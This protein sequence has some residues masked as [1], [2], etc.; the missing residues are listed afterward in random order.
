ML[1]LGLTGLY[2][3]EC[4]SVNEVE[5]RLSELMQSDA[6]A[7]IVDEYYR[8]R[9][10]EFFENRLARHAGLPLIIFCPSFEEEDPGTEAYINSIVKPAVG[11]EIRLD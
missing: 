6:Q 11:F 10:S 2:V 8:D 7:V 1:S 3:E 4:S 9:F 5:D